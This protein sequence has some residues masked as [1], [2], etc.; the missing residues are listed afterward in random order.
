MKHTDFD[1]LIISLSIIKIKLNSLDLVKLEEN[2]AEYFLNVGKGLK[3][4]LWNDNKYEDWKWMDL[5][6]N[7]REACGKHCFGVTEI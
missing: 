6:K 2:D 4:W 5:L 3:I 7:H 1:Y